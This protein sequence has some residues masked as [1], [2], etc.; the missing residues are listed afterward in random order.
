MENLRHTKKC[1]PTTYGNDKVLSSDP[2][3]DVDKLNI[4]DCVLEGENQLE[5]QNVVIR[6]PHPFVKTEKEHLSFNIIFQNI[7]LFE[8]YQQASIRTI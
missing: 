3:G 6:E 7:T 2:F 1:E 5:W 4:L 8:Q